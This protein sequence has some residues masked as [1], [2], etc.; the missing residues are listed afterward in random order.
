MA[1]TQMITFVENKDAIRIWEL[2]EEWNK[3]NVSQTIA[4][5]ISDW[6]K[7]NNKQ[8]IKENEQD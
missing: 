7:K 3:E 5:I 4:A 6:M 2:M 8:G 1:K